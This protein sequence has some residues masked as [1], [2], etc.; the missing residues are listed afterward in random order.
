MSKEGFYWD[1]SSGLGWQ[2]LDTYYLA[3][4]RTV[5]QKKIIIMSEV[6]MLEIPSQ[7]PLARLIGSLGR[8]TDAQQVAIHM[9]LPSRKAHLT[10]LQPFQSL[11]RSFWWPE[12][13]RTGTSL[14]HLGVTLGQPHLLSLRMQ[15]NVSLLFPYA[16]KPT[17]CS[18]P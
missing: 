14:N 8:G 6:Q 5:L 13:Y 12:L 2:I 4:K 11:D 9:G 18:K 7:V 3:Y 10:V 15:T 1:V 17:I 16:S